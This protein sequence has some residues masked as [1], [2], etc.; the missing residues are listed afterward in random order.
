VSSV[1]GW[2]KTHILIVV[3]GALILL[4]PPAGF[5]GS[6]FWNQKIKAAAEES[7][8]TEKRKLDGA[9]SV[10]YTLPPIAPGEQ[11][12]SDKRPPNA[13]ISRAYHAER[14]RRQAEIEKVVTRAV[15]FNKGEARGVLVPGL[16]PEAADDRTERE[17]IDRMM[18]ELVGSG[19]QASVYASLFDAINAGTPP[20]P[21]EAARL[22]A[23]YE[24]REL[25]RLVGGTDRGSLSEEDQ[26]ALVEG[27]RAQRI[28]FYRQRADEISVYGSVDALRDAVTGPRAAV[29]QT[30]LPPVIPNEVPQT[31]PTLAQAFAMQTD[32]WFVQ[33]L[34]SAVARANTE[35]G[36]LLTEVPRSAV[37]R[38][39]SIRLMPF[40]KAMAA[41][42]A[43]EDDFGG[44]GGGF[45]DPY[46]DPGY[47]PSGFG[48]GGAAASQWGGR[49]GGGGGGS[50]PAAGATGPTAQTHTGRAAAESPVY[51]IRRAVM[52]VVVASERLPE[53]I[54]AISAT[55]FMTVT[56]MTATPVDVW[57][58]LSE[59][60]FY[61]PEHVVR[62][63]LEVESAWLRQWTRDAMPPAVR[64]ALGVVMPE[65]PVE[66]GEGEDGFAD[67]EAQP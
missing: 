65:P 12:V 53:V 36:G 9:S 41:T 34:L 49:G 46:S 54:S 6:M 51:D 33:D 32:Y 15:L 44:G 14:E 21:V 43:E 17:L 27:M 16:F 5:V 3:F 19:D 47:N 24:E 8:S 38:I 64:D 56:G 66:E 25:D 58:D 63:T 67:E 11:A 35:A 2:I 48:G 52:T 62:V 57:A 39:E 30:G 50:T 60:Y 55:N 4:L 31:R 23:A 40:A 20:E 45:T 28:A 42:D 10:T 1:L 18:R 26:A 29:N 13:A 37:K 7:Y 59:G 61:G 22:V